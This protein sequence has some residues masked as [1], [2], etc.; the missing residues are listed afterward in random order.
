[1]WM[2]IRE[3]RS[4]DFML[5]VL[6][7]ERRYFGKKCYDTARD[8][9]KE[10]RLEGEDILC[11]DDLLGRPHPLRHGAHRVPG[12]R[13]GE[14]VAQPPFGRPEHRP[15]LLELP[16]GRNSDGD[17]P[18]L[19]ARRVPQLV[20]AREETPRPPYRASL[21]DRPLPRGGRL[22]GGNHSAED[23]PRGAQVYL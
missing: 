10:V 8:I 16:D 3:C 14:G 7:A 22:S 13:A 11:G 2:L 4:Q 1:M 15:H 9:L 21:R 18:H 6:E 12:R 20:G 23:V 19:L 17:F 5:I